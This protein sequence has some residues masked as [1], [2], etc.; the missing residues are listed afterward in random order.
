MKRTLL[1]SFAIGACGV[2]AFG[3]GIVLFENSNLSS[4][5]ITIAPGGQ[6]TGSGLVVELFWYNGSFF[7][8]EDTFTSTFTGAG[9]NGQNP[10][11]FSAGEVTIPMTGTQTFEVEAFYTSGYTPYSGTTA[12]FTATVATPPLYPP[13]SIAQFNPGPGGWN[14][15]LTFYLL[16]EPSPIALGGLGAAVLWLFRRRK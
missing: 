8:L 15:D 3:Q 13:S 6:P 11:Q 12:S 9:Q 1:T 14:G 16:P 10:G 4:A 2:A 5:A 7:V